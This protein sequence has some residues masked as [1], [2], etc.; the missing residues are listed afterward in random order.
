MTTRQY[1]YIVAMSEEV[2][3]ITKRWRGEY[4][5]PVAA[6]SPEEARQAALDKAR[7]RGVALKE[8]AVLDVRGGTRE[9]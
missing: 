3:G 1:R 9:V 5:M 7:A 4:L 2:G 6:S 8:T